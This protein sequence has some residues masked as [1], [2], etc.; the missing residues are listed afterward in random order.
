MKLTNKPMNLFFS[1]KK[2]CASAVLALA[3]AAN[4]QTFSYNNGDLLVGFRLTAGGNNDLVVKAGTAS[5]FTNLAPGTT[6]PIANFSGTL[7][8]NAFGTTNNL[9]FSA[10]GCFD[11][12]YPDVA[13]QNTLFMTA[14]RPDN[15]TQSS[16]W[17][18]W[19]ASA[20]GSARSKIDGAGLGAFYIG[21]ALPASVNTNQPN[22]LIEDETWNVS[23]NFSYNSM[24]GVSGDWG[25]FFNDLTEQSTSATFTSDGVPVRAELY[26]I[27]PGGNF[28]SHPPS[29]YLGYFELTTSGALTFNVPVTGAVTT[30]VITSITRVGSLT[31]VN[32]TTGGSGTYTLRASSTL[33]TP[34]AS[35]STLGSVSGNGAVQSLTETITTTP[36]FY[37]I[38]AQ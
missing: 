19:Y 11:G 5:S 30:P 35:W 32:F 37:M 2:V 29:A 15:N 27:V 38:S 36:R 18:R 20:Q 26:W 31:T 9:S 13:Q 24:L 6:L 12:S 25:G 17:R 21:S 16:P 4:A 8:K 22:Y 33:T 7:L 14:P 34:K 1:R 3:V 23:P 28:I 10:F